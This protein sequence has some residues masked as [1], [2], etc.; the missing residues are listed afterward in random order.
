MR[1]FLYLLFALCIM[2]A[3]CTKNRSSIQNMMAE[4]NINI[5]KLEKRDTLFFS[6]IFN[7]MAFIALSDCVPLGGRINR[8]L[9]HN[10]EIFII[11]NQ[12]VGVHVFDKQ[13]SYLRKIGSRGMG[14]G[15]M[16]RSCDMTI[17]RGRNFIYII[18]SQ[19]NIINKFDI[20]S[21]RF[22]ESISLPDE[23][24]HSHIVFQN[25][26]LYLTRYASGKNGVCHL[27][28]VIP[29]N[30]NDSHVIVPIGYN[31]GWSNLMANTNGPF[32]FKADGTVLF[33][34]R[35]MDVIFRYSDNELKP[36]IA[37]H[38]NEDD[39]VT[40]RDLSDFFVIRGQEDVLRIAGIEKFHDIHHYIETDDFIF[41][42]VSRGH[43]LPINILYNK[44]TKTA[45]RI[46][47]L[48]EDIFFTN[49][50][51]PRFGSRHNNIIIHHIHP[52]DLGSLLMMLKLGYIQDEE[53]RNFMEN[54]GDVYNESFNGIIL[55]YELK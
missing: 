3:S 42:R 9:L 25:D 2:L 4:I 41:F 5:D 23:G 27:F 54:I 31:K 8:V 49:R 16:M 32:L 15:E 24:R 37:L 13:G 34:H 20:A 53:F 26:T 12:T 6:D 18:D 7:R 17:D 47:V 19:I 48:S 36:Y 29:I 40:P 43:T 33:S 51:P 1:D 30:G 11:D 28:R 45:E 38:G 55:L 39:F 10:E 22:Q 44:I 52:M 50:P 14:P 35:F 46:E 21:G